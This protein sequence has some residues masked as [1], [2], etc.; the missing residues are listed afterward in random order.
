MI[1]C[2]L[3]Y[4][5]LRKTF[6][7]EN[8]VC[9]FLFRNAVFLGEGCFYGRLFDMGNYPG[10][11]ESHVLKTKVSG[12]I[13]RL[14]KPDKILWQLDQY[15]GLQYYRKP[16]SVVYKGSNLLCWVYLLKNKPIL[17]KEI[18]HGDYLYWMQR[19]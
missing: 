11:M 3:V 18:T 13:F 8:D 9:R 14:K 2:L 6:F 1:S 15:E 16:V 4:G 19:K 7:S 10:A 5:T 17:F 12:D